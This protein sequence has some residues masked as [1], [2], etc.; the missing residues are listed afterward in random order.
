[1]VKPIDGIVTQGRNSPLAPIQQ[2]VTKYKVSYS[3][4]GINWRYYCEN[5]VEKVTQN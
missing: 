1:M 5:K 2:R 4:D 3:E